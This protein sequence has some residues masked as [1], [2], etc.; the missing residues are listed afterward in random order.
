[1]ASPR[2]TLNI[3]P[4][5]PEEKR[6]YTDKE[7]FQNFMHYNKFYFIG[8]AIALILLLFFIHDVSQVENPDMQIAIVSEK[9]LPEAALTE[10]EIELAPFISDINND[11]DVIL[12]VVQYNLS[13]GIAEE[14][15]VAE[16]NVSDSSNT[17]AASPEDGVELASAAHDPYVQMAS[18]TKLS[19]DLQMGDSML[20]LVE[21]VEQFQTAYGVLSY[22]DG[23]TPPMDDTSNLENVGF[24]WQN[25]EFLTGL[26][27]T[28]EDDDFGN[29]YDVHEMFEGYTMAL[30]QF[31]DTSISNDEDN[32]I[33][34]E[35]ATDLFNQMQ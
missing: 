15:E 20:F 3:S 19:G 14:T 22:N 13:V 23:S 8:G 18:V 34:Y 25:S 7:K 4:E 30:R 10:L 26:D 27:L 5:E 11:G 24:Q 32:I 12:S 16:S 33:A 29:T 35:H 28:V 21:D 31:E 2:Y 17:E 1:M 6:I 9:T